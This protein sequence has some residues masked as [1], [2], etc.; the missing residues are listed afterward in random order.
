MWKFCF[1]KFSKSKIYNLIFIW[2]RIYFFP[3]RIQDPDLDTLKNVMD[4]K[5]YDEIM[6]AEDEI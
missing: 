2:I 3:V 1:F 5:H 6:K 4:P